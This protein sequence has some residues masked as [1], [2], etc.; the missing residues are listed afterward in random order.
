MP[1]SRIVTEPIV[2]VIS[3]SSVGRD[4]VRALLANKQ[5]A[6]SAHA[7]ITFSIA[8]ITASAARDVEA[9]GGV[10]S[11]E[12]YRD[13]D[14]LR[15]VLPALLLKI[16]GRPDCEEAREWQKE[17]EYAVANYKRWLAYMEDVLITQ[18]EG[19]FKALQRPI[20]E[21][22]RAS[23]P[24]S[25]ET[26]VIWT[27]TYATLHAFLKSAANKDTEFEM[28][29]LAIALFNAVD[30]MSPEFFLDIAIAEPKPGDLVARLETVK[31]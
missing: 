24:N 23:L 18:G 28:C 19:N 4:V 6:V 8:G 9:A 25:I 21:A 14:S 7:T 1:V 20:L 10:V 17:Q 22:A 29:Q 2:S 31:A 3:A 5:I 11:F 26:P 27:C 12:R 16:W 15:Y 13:A 30:A